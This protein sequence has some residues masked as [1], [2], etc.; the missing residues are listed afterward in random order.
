[1]AMDGSKWEFTNLY[2]RMGYIEWELC[3]LEHVISQF[4]SNWVSF[5]KTVK[6]NPINQRI[7]IICFPVSEWFALNHKAHAL[8]NNRFHHEV[9]HGLRHICF[10]FRFTP[11]DSKQGK[12]L[13]INWLH[14]K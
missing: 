13:Q 10:S 2:S 1:M 9:A 8:D 4:A 14:V 7:I 11:S 3:V 12:C 6:E 5:D